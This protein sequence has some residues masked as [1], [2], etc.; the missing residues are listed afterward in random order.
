MRT[1]IDFQAVFA[2][3]KKGLKKYEK[4]C[5]VDQDTKSEYYLNMPKLDTNGKPIFF[6]AT[7]VN[8]ISVSYY[9]M[10]LFR[11]TDL[12][13][14]I[15]P[16]LRTH[17]HGKSCFRFVKLEPALLRELSALTNKCFERC[18]NEL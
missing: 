16:E 1:S 3:L 8:K 5:I 14:T 12:R 18:K 10:P 17:L 6:A 11:F 15:S 9:L 2:Q 4:H 13:E 7:G